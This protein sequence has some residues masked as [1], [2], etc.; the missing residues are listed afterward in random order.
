MCSRRLAMILCALCAFMVVG[1]NNDTVQS[2]DFSNF[3]INENGELWIFCRQGIIYDAFC[4][5]FDEACPAGWTRVSILD[6]PAT[7]CRDSTGN[8]FWADVE[9]CQPDW[10]PVEGGCLNNQP[11][12]N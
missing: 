9:Q 4:A 10:T 2:P 12:C 7:C 1:C 8:A 6:L 3:P 5:G 11:L